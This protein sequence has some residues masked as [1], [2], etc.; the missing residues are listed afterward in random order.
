MLS[1]L[2]PN[3]RFSDHGS[4]F[5]RFT[6]DRACSPMESARGPIGAAGTEHRR[7]EGRQWRCSLTR[8][9]AA[10]RAVLLL[11]HA[12]TRSGADPP[13]RPDSPACLHECVGVHP[14]GL[15][16]AGVTRYHGLRP[17]IGV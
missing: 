10:V 16:Q 7:E 4:D 12:P 5:G 14:Y 1:R 11:R 2:P 9:E 8:P 13:T 3:A 15:A 6:P 17:D